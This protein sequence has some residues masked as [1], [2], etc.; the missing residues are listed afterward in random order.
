MGPFPFQ[1]VADIFL[2]GFLAT[3]LV[4]CAVATWFS[5]R[6]RMSYA[7]AGA[8]GVAIAWAAAPSLAQSAGELV[9]R[10]QKRTEGARPD[11]QAFFESVKGR[12][13]AYREQAQAVVDG[14]GSAAV[15][16]RGFADLEDT[17]FRGGGALATLGD[18]PANPQGVVYVAVKGSFQQTLV[19]AKQVF[20][21]E[22]VGGVA[23][24]PN[25]FR[26][27][28]IQA[29]PTFIAAKSPV[30]PC[31]AGID[32][33]PAAP[34]HDRVSGNITLG[35]ALQALRD[36]QGVGTGAASAASQKLGD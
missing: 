13:G 14:G 2:A 3:V 4:G 31:G 5:G 17:D 7:L 9:E 1:T 28:N 25:V 12:E 27:F 15:L 18:E 23:I 20:D 16:N 22:S 8:L 11:A 36:A 6:R 30:Q 19:R 33:V 29:V 21:E 10:V 26:A 24:D 34:D 35:A 32:C